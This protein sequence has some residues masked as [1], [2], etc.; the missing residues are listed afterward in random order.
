MQNELIDYLTELKNC[1]DDEAVWNCFTKTSLYHGYNISLYVLVSTADLDKSIYL[2]NYKNDWPKTYIENNYSDVDPVFKYIMNSKTP[3][4]SPM[5]L[6]TDNIEPIKDCGSR[7]IDYY[8]GLKEAGL[9]RA[10]NIPLTYNLEYRGSV[11]LGTNIMTAKEFYAATNE[12]LTML[13]GIVMATHEI[14]KLGIIKK[15]ASNMVK[16]TPRQNDLLKSLAKGLT[17]KK[18]S[19]LL[20]ISESTVSFHIADLQNALGCSVNREIV[21]SAISMGLLSPSDYS[22]SNTK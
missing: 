22:V 19:E 11:S 1:A 9:D 6:D 8:N 16:L 2:H 18:I 5:I 10:L 12:K 14:L 21:P 7:G 20:N 3:V 13:H 17:N 4:T 15:Y